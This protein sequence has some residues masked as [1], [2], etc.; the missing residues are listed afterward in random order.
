MGNVGDELPLILLQRI[1][2]GGHII[3]G[4]SQVT[5][6]IIGMEID[7]DIKIPGS[8]RVGSFGDLAD[9]DVHCPGEN[10]KNHK[11]AENDN[12]QRGIRNI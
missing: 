8:I 3:Q 6:L 9:R 7:L 2:L 10:P 5:Q 4:G 1:Q 12:S 11:G